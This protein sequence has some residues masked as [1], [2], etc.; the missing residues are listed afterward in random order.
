MARIVK[1]L[2]KLWSSH[3]KGLYITIVRENRIDRVCVCLER[4]VD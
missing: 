3:I 2:K 4:L 1:F